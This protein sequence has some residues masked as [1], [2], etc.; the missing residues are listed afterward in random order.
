VWGATNV[1]Q[2][3]RVRKVAGCCARAG[4]GHAAAAPPTS[5]IKLRRLIA[6]LKARDIASSGSNYHTEVPGSVVSGPIVQYPLWVI[7]CRDCPQRLC[8]P[9]PPKT[10][11]TIGSDVFAK[12]QKATF[13]APWA[14]IKQTLS[15]LGAG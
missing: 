5:D 6:S 12:C 11:A 9:Y 15:A 7:T 8:P 2:R 4:N 10:A 13:G 3:T 1:R 14:T